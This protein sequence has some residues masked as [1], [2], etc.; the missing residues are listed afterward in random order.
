[1]GQLIVAHG[2]LLGFKEGDLSAKLRSSQRKKWKEGPATHLT[3]SQRP[4][5]TLCSLPPVS[6]VCG[7]FEPVGRATFFVVLSGFFSSPLPPPL[8]SSALENATSQTGSPGGTHS[9]VG[10]PAMLAQVCWRASTKPAST[11]H[12]SSQLAI[13]CPHF[14]P[15]LPSWLEV[16]TSRRSAVS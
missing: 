3:P 5:Q 12:L 16:K 1:M 10:S 8:E 11:H 9:S 13:F 7:F 6:I 4:S 14:S 15:S 2:G